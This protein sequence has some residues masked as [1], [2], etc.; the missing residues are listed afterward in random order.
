MLLN[1]LTIFNLFHLNHP[2]ILYSGILKTLDLIKDYALH[3]VVICK[4]SFM[5][6]I[7]LSNV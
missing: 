7:F 1:R 2:N 3:L 5:H 4:F 6:S